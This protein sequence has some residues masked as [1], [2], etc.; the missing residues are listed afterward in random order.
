MEEIKKRQLEEILTANPLLNQDIS[1]QQ[2]GVYSLKKRW[3]EETVFKNQSRTAPKQKKTFI[4]DTVRSDF[5]RKFL[6]RF[7]Q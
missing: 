7:I 3:Y 2:T 5:H 6:N 4:N 1:E